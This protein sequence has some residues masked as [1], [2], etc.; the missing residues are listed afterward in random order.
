MPTTRAGT[1]V[2]SDSR[3]VRDI[4]Y[5]GNPIHERCTVI[6]RIAPTFLRF[7]SFEI[8]KVRSLPVF[9]KAGYTEAKQLPTDQPTDI[10]M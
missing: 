7:G 8:F 2:T 6:T 5:D 1:C 10:V 9:I 4:F 3:V